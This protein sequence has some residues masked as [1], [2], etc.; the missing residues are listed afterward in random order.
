MVIIHA[1]SNELLKWR[2]ILCFY[3]C[4]LSMTVFENNFLLIY[5]NTLRF[6][7]ELPKLVIISFFY[8]HLFSFFV[9][10]Y[11]GIFFE[12]FITFAN[13]GPG[14]GPFTHYQFEA[15]ICQEYPATIQKYI[16]EVLLQTLPAVRPMK[17]TKSTPLKMFPLL[18]RVHAPNWSY[19]HLVC[20][21]PSF[22][23]FSKLLICDFTKDEK[24]LNSICTPVTTFYPQSKT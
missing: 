17:G 15:P 5:N 20:Y 23:E 24:D 19:M 10:A 14:Y 21:G 18:L 1:M 13:T 9:V 2:M 6:N 12:C 16:S 7:I 11:L 3:T 22:L 8:C 4:H